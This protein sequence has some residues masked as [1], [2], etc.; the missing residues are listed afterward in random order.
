MKNEKIKLPINKKISKF[1]NLTFCKNKISI[2]QNMIGDTILAVQG[3]KTRDIIGTSELN[4]CI[5]ELETLYE[6][7]NNINI[8]IHTISKKTDINN[9]IAQLQKINNELSSMFRSFGT[10]N[11]EDL[12]AVAF[13]T[14]FIQKNI[15]DEHRI[16]WA[17]IQKY[18][19][20][21]APPGGGTHTGEYFCHHAPYAFKTGDDRLYSGRDC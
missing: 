1:D 7:L 13:A 20:C 3:Y 17:L 11:I 8:K 9:I 5:Q 10:K 4:I 19:I 14:D 2:F 16:K 6:D 21:G 12:V 15:T 18:R